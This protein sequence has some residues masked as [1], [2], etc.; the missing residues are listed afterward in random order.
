M[1]AKSG[2]PTII[3]FGRLEWNAAF[4]ASAEQVLFSLFIRLSSSAFQLEILSDLSP[5]KEPFPQVLPLFPTLSLGFLSCPCGEDWTEIIQ[6]LA[7]F[8]LKVLWWLLP[9]LSL[10]AYRSFVLKFVEFISFKKCWFCLQMQVHLLLIV[11]P[12]WS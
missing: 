5:P 3:V 11:R 1:V 12:V 9:S 10:C 8:L 6:G 4:Q 2:R 7:E